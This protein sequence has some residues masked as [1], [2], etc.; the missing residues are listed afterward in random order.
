MQAQ[1]TQGEGLNR[2]LTV[3]IPAATVAEKTEARF[4]TLAKTV[5][6]DGFR[7]GKVPVKVVKERL[8]DQVRA[9][10]AREL[11]Q[12]FLPQ[13]LKQEK[14]NAA[15]QPNIRTQEGAF[16][17]PAEGDFSFTADFEVYPAFEP[18]GYTK[19]KLTKETAEADE[20][21]VNSA[22]KRLESQMA[23]FK[24]KEGKAAMGD[25]VTITGQG[26]TAVGGKEEAFPGG[27]LNDF[28]VVL[29]S[30]QLIP[31]FED[32]LVGSK[33]GDQV[34]LQ[35]S[36]PADYHAKELA[37]QP[38]VFK[39]AI[40]LIEAPEDAPLSDES[41]QQLGFKTLD[42]LKDVLKRGAARDL[43]AATQQRLKRQLLDALDSANQFDVPQGLVNTEHAALWRAQ[44]QE[45][46]QRRLPME[47]LGKS[48]EEAIAE[49]KPLAVRRVK[50]GLILA[51]IAKKHE[52]TVSAKDVDQAVQAQ[53]AAA[54]P[55][56]AQARQYFA[57]P[58]NR[59]QL[60]GPL[61]EDKVTGWLL[62]NAE[63]AEKKVPA[64][65]LLAEIQ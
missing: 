58:A 47:A 40:N 16:S 1:L 59:M 36:F 13:A 65:E 6:L 23:S 15:G 55:Q 64:T 20:D 9:D 25:R 2:S 27:N 41:V 54:G 18:T 35:V 30:G 52:L 50:L 42:E 61:L 29:G 57:D 28:K 38:A 44:L 24:A 34:D 17:V 11:V 49:L 37:G 8:A 21:M 33:V 62:E 48:P 39:L 3:T 19:L 12:E 32:G 10:V 7:P 60:N 53:I 45:L 56:A 22:L 14:Q 63:V 46:Q 4:V 51:E 26:Y 43:E 5:K 31:G